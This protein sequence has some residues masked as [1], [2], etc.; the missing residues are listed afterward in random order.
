VLFLQTAH[1]PPGTN[2][3]QRNKR[4]KCSLCMLQLQLKEADC[5]DTEVDGLS[6]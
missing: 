5:A 1:V 3:Q 6:V 2:Q 4:R